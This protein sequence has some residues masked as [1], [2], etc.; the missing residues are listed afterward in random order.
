MARF[1]KEID[2]NCTL[3]AIGSNRAEMLRALTHI[4]TYVQMETQLLP[5]VFHFRSPIDEAEADRILT[6]LEPHI[7]R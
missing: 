3:A 6:A 1:L 2:L 4:H 7:G 5:G